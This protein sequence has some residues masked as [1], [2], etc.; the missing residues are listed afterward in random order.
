MSQA[1]S[2][3]NDKMRRPARKS[4]SLDCTCDGHVPFCPVCL[5]QMA[6]AMRIAH[7]STLSIAMLKRRIVGIDGRTAALLLEASKLYTH[8]AGRAVW[9][10]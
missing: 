2:T 1:A 8:S 4:Q 6:C 3:N 7:P 10:F 5:V 9:G